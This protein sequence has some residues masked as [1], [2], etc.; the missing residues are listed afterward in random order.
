M[1]DAENFF[2]KVGKDMSKGFNNLFGNK[3]RILADNIEV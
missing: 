2:D 3:E 1:G